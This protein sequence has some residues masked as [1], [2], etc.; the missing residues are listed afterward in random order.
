MI[1]YLFRC[2]T[3][4]SLLAAGSGPGL[5]AQAAD[6]LHPVQQDVRALTEATFGGDVE[7]TLG[8]THP[9]GLKD[10][11]GREAARKALVQLQEEFSSSGMKVESLSFPSP[12][13]FLETEARRFAIVPTLTILSMAGLR[14]EVLGFHIGVLEPDAKGWTYVDGA[15][16][17]GS[18]VRDFFPDFPG[19]YTFP[20]VHSKPL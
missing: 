12:P 11:G 6:E 17:N 4:A 18:N 8:F 16:V 7:T 15:R 3:L 19:G 9:T 14:L 5:A 2:V 1:R 10:A 20:K 13:D